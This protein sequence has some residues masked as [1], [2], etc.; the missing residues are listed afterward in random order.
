MS[1]HGSSQAPFKSLIIGSGS[2]LPDRVV[3]NAD[4]SESLDTTDEW[5]QSRVGISTRHFLSDDESII[6]IA[7]IACERALETAG[8]QATDIDLIVVG[9]TTN[10]YIFPSMATFIQKELKA[11]KACAFD[12]Q[13]ACSGFIYALSVGDNM[14]KGGQFKTVLVVGSEAMSRLV[15]QKDRSTAVIF[16]DGAG[17]V[18]LQA[19]T[20]DNP[21]GI[22]STHLYSDGALTNILYADGGSGSGC[23]QQP[24]FMHGREVFRHAIEK[25]GEATLAALESNGLEAADIDW[26]IP[27]QAN[28]RIIHGVADHFNLPREK[29]IITLGHHGNTSAASI[30]LALDEA[31]RLGKVKEGDLIIFEGLGA[32]LTWGSVALRF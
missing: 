1:S 8:I 19:T 14:I 32:G 26:F 29:I 15:D 11:T 4:F 3:S 17:A 28:I 31:V 10:P 13:A 23:A 18:I 20:P 30:P 9:T 24:V 2:C 22:L 7:R 6:P 5:I 16:G 25:L 21:R 12:V 27:H